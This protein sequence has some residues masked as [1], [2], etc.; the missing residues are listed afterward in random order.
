MFCCN[1]T[2]AGGLAYWTREIT[3]C[4]TDARCIRSRRNDVSAAFFDSEEFQQTGFFVYR[5]YSAGLGRRLSYAEFSAD[6]LYVL[7]GVNL[8]ESRGAFSKV[9]VQRAEFVRKYEDH[10]TGASFVD[11]LLA[12]VPSSG[13]DMSSL[14]NSLIASYQTGGD[15]NQSRALVLRQLIDNA[16]FKQSEYNPSFVL[17]EYFGYLRRDPDAGG[18]GFWL[19]VL[20][21]ARLEIIA[22]WFAPLSRRQS[23][24]AASVQSS[25]TAIVTVDS[26][27]VARAS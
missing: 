8:E 3:K 18:Y 23:I 11:A 13:V 24:S 20:I 7:D 25:I 14:R 16:A 21:R 10:L 17:M 22:V 6:H 4:G 19:D 15:L 27:P 2:D 26:R 12:T 5:M 9:F 1:G